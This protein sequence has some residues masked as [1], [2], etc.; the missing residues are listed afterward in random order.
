M[1]KKHMILIEMRKKKESG[2]KE[3]KKKKMKFAKNREKKE[4]EMTTK[5][6]KI[7]LSFGV[8]SVNGIQ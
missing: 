3:R 5:L 8:V 7:I 1:I 4:E 2:V 6:G